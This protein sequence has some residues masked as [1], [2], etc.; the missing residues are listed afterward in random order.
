MRLINLPA[1]TLFGEDNLET[2]MN[3]AD[4]EKSSADLEKVTRHTLMYRI[5]HWAMA[6]AVLILM[7]T[8]FLPILGIKF[9]W[10]DIHWISGVVLAILIL[11]HIVRAVIWQDWRNMIVWP[12]DIRD[13]WR[14]FFALFSSTA[15]M[16]ARPGKFN[17]L[18]KLYHL[19]S[20]VF[21]LAI[22]ATGLLMMVKIDTPFWRR[23]PYLLSN[24]NNR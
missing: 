2:E 5:Y 1:A 24:L 19:G 12:S 7:G 4:L 11:I 21:V 16:P 14:G 20:A 18:Q 9:E 17:P 23:N 13:V 6:L 15:T 10:I 8:A 22:I 3:F